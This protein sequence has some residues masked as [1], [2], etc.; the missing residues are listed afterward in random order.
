MKRHLDPIYQGEKVHF[1][2]KQ[3]RYF[4]FTPLLNGGSTRLRKNFLLYEL[5]LSLKGTLVSKMKSQKLSPFVK[6]MTNP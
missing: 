6:M 4:H 5:I 3:L 1:Q 2:G